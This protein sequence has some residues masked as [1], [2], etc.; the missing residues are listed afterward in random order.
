[1]ACAGLSALACGAA[2]ETAELAEMEDTPVLGS[3]QQALVSAPALSASPGT[4]CFTD[5]RDF[6][7]GVGLE[8]P[9]SDRINVRSAHSEAVL[10]GTGIGQDTSRVHLTFNVTDLDAKWDSPNYGPAR[11]VCAEAGVQNA[12]N[13]TRACW[14]ADGSWRVEAKRNPGQE[15]LDECGENGVTIQAQNEATEHL[16]A[17]QATSASAPDPERTYTISLTTSETTGPTFLFFQNGALLHWGTAPAAAP[18]NPREGFVGFRHDRLPVAVKVSGAPDPCPGVGS[19]SSESATLLAANAVTPE[20]TGFACGYYEHYQPPFRPLPTTGTL[21]ALSSLSVLNN[22]YVPPQSCDPHVDL[23]YQGLPASAVRLRL[24]MDGYEVGSFGVNG[25]QGPLNVQAYLIEGR[26]YSFQLVWENANGELS[27]PALAR[28]T[29]PNTCVKPLT[30]ASDASLDSLAVLFTYPDVP[31]PTLTPTEADIAIFG[32]AT[33]SPSAYVTELS[34]GSVDFVGTTTDWLPLNNTWANECQGHERC[35]FGTDLASQAIARGINI[36]GY[37]SVMFFVNG[38]FD[39]NTTAYLSGQQLTNLRDAGLTEIFIHEFLGHRL[40][41][42][43]HSGGF[44]CGPKSTVILGPNV[45]DASGARSIQAP[46]A[47]CSLSTY[48]DQQSVMGSSGGGFHTAGTLSS[49][50]TEDLLKQRWISQA[51]VVTDEFGGDYE[52]GALASATPT[53]QIKVQLFDN[54]FYFLEYRVPGGI[55]ANRQGVQIRLLESVRDVAQPAAMGTFLPGQ[56]A[57]DPQNPQTLLLTALPMTGGSYCDPHRKVRIEVSNL[58]SSAAH[59]R[60][61]RGPCQPVEIADG[62]ACVSEHECVSGF[63]THGICAREPANVQVSKGFA[64]ALFDGGTIKCWGSND[65]GQTG[66]TITPNVGDAPG[67]MG[68]ALTAVPL[69][70]PALQFSLGERHGCAVLKTN[71]VECWGG[72][73]K[74]QLGAGDTVNRVGSVVPVPLDFT[75]RQVALGRDFSCALFGSGKVK[76]WGANDYGQLGTGN[77][78]ILGD[79]PNEL[80]GTAPFNFGLV[81]SIAAGGSHACIR[82]ISGEVRCWGLAVAGQLGFSAGFA[83]GDEP[84]ETNPPRV[85][86]GTNFTAKEIALGSNHSCALNNSGQIKCWGINNYGQLGYDNTATR[87]LDPAGMGDNLLA[88]P[89]TEDTDRLSAGGFATCARSTAGALRCWGH[90]NSLGQPTAMAPC[91]GCRANDIENL[92]P[93][94]LG[95]GVLA[96]QAA[97]SDLSACAILDDKHVKCWGKNATGALGLGDTVQR[98]FAGSPLGDALPVLVLE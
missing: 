91:V 79:E 70:G 36:F 68:A 87:G 49:Y 20:R 90:T 66:S 7:V 29:T 2:S 40:G 39:N 10:G 97:T 33:K 16:P 48:A 54:W 89:L 9:Q 74:G 58:T 96:Q 61:V 17:L 11:R 45:A 59:V 72:N 1:V 53:K 93:I 92:A 71:T 83:Y 65:V 80:G 60:V 57:P 12:C 21:P 25:P 14:Y 51:E 6:H 85:E 77:T 23:Q 19:C 8:Q 44:S 63:C 42:L 24:Y 78:Q 32:N 22:G 31:A 47:V 88:V 18:L 81:Q 56:S 82:K 67:E 41:L 26:T 55:T 86:L 35:I 76:C 64:C 73:T 13:L 94:A 84:N 37:D 30:T 3:A 27:K 98:G 28:V 43:G 15:S 46:D 38:A 95:T 50:H 52:L 5:L 62:Q 4:V 34:R 75:V 69:S